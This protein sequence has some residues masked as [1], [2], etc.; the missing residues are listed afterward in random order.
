MSFRWFAEGRKK[1]V[2]EPHPLPSDYTEEYLKGL[3]TQSGKIEFDCQSLRRFDADDPERP[4][5]VKYTP[6]WEGPHTTEMVKDYPLQMITPHAR[7]S[8]HSQGDGKDAYINDIRDH[9]ILVDGH[10]YWTLRL[11]DQDAR[12]TGHR[13]EPADQ[14]VQSPG[15]GDLRRLSDQPVTA[16]RGPWLRVL[17]HL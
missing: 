14:G 2:P 12:R 1:N 16:R 15:R 3:Q 6:S 17:R 9:R 8:Y 13:N 4:P 10:F 5:V 11:N 7:Y